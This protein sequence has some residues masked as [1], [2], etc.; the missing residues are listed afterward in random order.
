MF[1]HCYIAHKEISILSWNGR[2][3]FHF[4]LQGA[5]VSV[6]SWESQFKTQSKGSANLLKGQ[7]N[8]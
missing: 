2:L 3:W 8:I 4:K 6:T 5:F 7:S 1:V